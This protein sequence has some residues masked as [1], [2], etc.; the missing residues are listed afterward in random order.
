MSQT[1][2]QI[3]EP[4]YYFKKKSD[5]LDYEVWLNRNTGFVVNGFIDKWRTKI[6]SEENFKLHKLPCHTL[7]RQKDE[8]RRTKK[9]GKLCHLDENILIEDCWRTTNGKYKP[10]PCGCCLR[11]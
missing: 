11:N 1:A 3:S 8:G 10:K 9:Y 5:E 6:D 2:K 7:K 4:K